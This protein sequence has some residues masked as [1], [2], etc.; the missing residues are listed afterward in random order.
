M[1][2]VEPDRKYYV[3]V[4]NGERQLYLGAD[5]YNQAKNNAEKSEGKVWNILKKQ[6]WTVEDF[7]GSEYE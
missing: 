3:P 5:G 2:N 6:G 4:M 7:W 1:I